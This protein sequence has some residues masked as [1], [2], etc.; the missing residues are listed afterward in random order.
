[1]AAASRLSEVVGR[2]LKALCRW[3]SLPPASEAGITAAFAFLTD[4]AMDRPPVAPFSGFSQ[5]NA[6]GLPFQWSFCFDSSRGRS[7]R[8]LCEA[9][10]PGEGAISRYRHSTVQLDRACTAL[11]IPH[12]RWL[13]DI[14]FAHTLPPEHAWPAH[15]R[16]A[17]WFGV[18]ASRNGLLIKP[19]INLNDGD[20]VVRW[21]RVGHVLHA[22]GR[23][24]ALEELCR[25]SG[26]VS[27]GSWLTGMTVD[28]LPD[29]TPGRLKIYFRCAEVAATW[30]ARWYD[31]V[32][33]TDELATVRQLLDAFPLLGSSRYPARSLIVGLEF[34]EDDGKISLKTDAAV[35]R[36][37]PDDRAIVTGTRRL[38][39]ALELP[40][41]ELVSAL[42]SIGAWP[43]ARGKATLQRFVGVGY[44]PNGGRHLNLYLEP[45]LEGVSPGPRR[46]VRTYDEAIHDGMDFL[47]SACRDGHWIDFALPV[48]EADAW[49]TAYVL[50][51]IADVPPRVL[52]YRA[53]RQLA[54][55]LD[56]LCAARTS[57]GGWGY[58]A[59]TGDDADSTALAILALRQHGRSVPPDALSVI[60]RCVADE[61]GVGTY[62]HGAAPG[63][64]WT[65]A[66]VDVTSSALAAL[67]EHLTERERRA[68]LD[69]LEREQ[70]CDGTWRS[71]W[72]VTPLYATSGALEWWTGGG[73]PARPVPRVAEL[74]ATLRRFRPM[75]A[76]ETAMLI[77]CLRHLGHPQ[78]ADSFGRQLLHEQRS[79]GSWEPSAYL[80][81]THPDIAQPWSAIDAGPIFVDRQAAFTTATVLAALSKC[82]FEQQ[83]RGYKLIGRL[84]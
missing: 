65:S 12:P 61:G 29:G 9:G 22:L 46:P 43:P 5:I 41:S 31:A 81:L 45:P 84:A 53:R 83:L 28:V 8:F 62:P 69:F 23:L 35:T 57:G 42:S 10:I 27:A 17:V 26:K 76:F 3:A 79:D 36:L 66:V 19:Y 32:G 30:L 15:W 49:V 16:S 51:R 14:V 52:S 77:T 55:T 25:L 58:N 47:L 60:R 71:F 20:P 39:G 80:R 59:S 78:P 4:G 72:W 21:R 33:A 11:G 70:C 56:W 68:S 64:A 24:A 13:W 63:Q 2:Q 40:D 37:L 50:H 74:Q 75:G 1:M 34:H 54:E 6:D 44:E 82:A 73:P 48:G 7:V 38:M 67:S 18:G